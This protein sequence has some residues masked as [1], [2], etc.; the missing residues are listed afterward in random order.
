MA[1]NDIDFSR[2]RVLIIE[3]DYH[4]RQVIKLAFSQLRCNRVLEAS[5]GERGIE[6]YKVAAEQL[7]VIGCDLNMPV[8]DGYGFVR[9]VRQNMDQRAKDIPII[10]LTATKPTEGVVKPLAE[11]GVQGYLVKPVTAGALKKQITRALS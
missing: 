1:E 5:D 9:H 6:V 7:D 10:I 4:L 11:L 8:L 2:L 3:D